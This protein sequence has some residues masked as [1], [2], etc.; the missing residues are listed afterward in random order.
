MINIRRTPAKVHQTQQLSAIQ[1]SWTYPPATHTGTAPGKEPTAQHQ[2][3]TAF[4]GHIF[5]INKLLRKEPRVRPQF[6]AEALVLG[7]LRVAGAVFTAEEGA[8]GF[9]LRCGFSCLELVMCFESGLLHCFVAGGYV[10]WCPVN[11][12]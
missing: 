9:C 8:A 4:A 1:N 11:R 12:D 2:F 6:K 3:N 10:G 7:F 5:Q